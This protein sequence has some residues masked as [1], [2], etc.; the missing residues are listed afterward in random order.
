MS[1]FERG[2]EHASISRAL[3]A[4]ESLGLD[5]V[6]LPRGQAERVLQ[7]LKKLG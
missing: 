6:V 7:A 3:R 2:K 5:L 4:L 1:E